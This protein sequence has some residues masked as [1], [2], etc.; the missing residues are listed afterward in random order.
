M[1]RHHQQ[2]PEIG[3][4]LWPI[5]VP[6]LAGLLIGLAAVGF[7]RLRR[8]RWTWALGALPLAYLGWLISWRAG[9][10]LSVGGATAL[11]LSTR[12]HA[13]AIG[14]GGEEA[15]AERDAIGPIAAAR[16]ALGERRAMRHRRR[17]GS[18]AIGRSLRG[19]V[20]WVP[21]GRPGHGA[22]SLI[23]GSTGYG[24]TVSEATILEA[25][26]RD[27]QAAIVID[28]KGDPQLRATAQASA[29]AAG[30]EFRLW[31]PRGPAPY[32]PLR[33]G[34]RS[35][36]GDKAL[37]AHQWSEPHYELATRR[38][39][40]HALATMQAVGEWP[41]TLAGLAAAM[42]PSRLDALAERAGGEVAR[43]VHGYLDSLGARAEKDTGGGRDRLAVLA[44]SEIGPWLAPQSGREEIDLARALDEREVVYFSLDSDRYPAASAL[45]AAAIVA[46][47]VSLSAERQGASTA[48]LVVIDEFAAIAARQVSR[49]FARSRGAGISL[50]LATQTLADLRAADPEADALGDQVA[51]NVAYVLAHRIPDPDSAE[52]LARMAGTEPAWTITEA[53]DRGFLAGPR[54]EGTRTRQRD[55]IIGPDTFKRLAV[56]EA[57]L[58][59]A[60]VSP[61]AQ[62]VRIWR[63]RQVPDF[64]APGGRR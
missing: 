56:G 4:A 32:N 17:D 44:E 22:H 54:G 21:I 2:A 43:R 3:A 36:I 35:E 15:R 46:D 60:S 45:L 47:L 58:L 40:G 5:A 53:V 9:L 61:P 29:A 14:R 52:R 39:V 30:A 51:S 59:D 27:G 28:P 7:L 64:K 18:L 34:S 12:L 57:I 63:P 6:I 25:H 37:S 50:L 13:E 31:T 41:P 24:K 26:V 10:T 11:F 48:A 42:Q 1:K 20:C 62:V 16:S 8:L 55:F 33:R 38:L 19:S 49:L 23:L